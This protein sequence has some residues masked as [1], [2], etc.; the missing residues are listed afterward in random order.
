MQQ[1]SR[2]HV[3]SLGEA[4]GSL[5]KDGD[6]YEG[7]IHCD[8]RNASTYMRASRSMLRHEYVRSRT[9][10][11]DISVL[12]LHRLT[13]ICPSCLS[14]HCKSIYCSCSLKKLSNCQAYE[15]CIQMPIS[16]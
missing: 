14:A 13:W 8:L 4:A 5:S 7:Q 3:G 10:L 1:P 2:M 15:S 9:L 11:A 12:A 16:F 6:S